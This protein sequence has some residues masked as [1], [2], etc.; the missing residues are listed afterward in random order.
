MP[1]KKKS[2]TITSDTVEKIRQHLDSLPTPV[3]DS[4][5][6]R[7]A[8]NLL[9]P[10]ITALREK[11][12]TLAE[13]ATHLNSAGLLVAQSTLRNYARQPRTKRPR[14]PT[15][16]GVRKAPAPRK[17]ADPSPAPSPPQPLSSSPSASLSQNSRSLDIEPKSKRN[18]TFTLKPDRTKI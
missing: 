12:Y 18:S 10:Q 15:P 13:I 2:A 17:T 1:G 8:V 5:S 3:S 7:K 14:N 11:G 6:I 16:T 4:L 9:V